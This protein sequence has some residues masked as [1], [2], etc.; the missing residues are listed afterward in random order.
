MQMQEVEAQIPEG[1]VLSVNSNELACII[2]SLSVSRVTT[3]SIQILVHVLIS[4]F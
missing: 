2:K 3:L 4:P 1:W